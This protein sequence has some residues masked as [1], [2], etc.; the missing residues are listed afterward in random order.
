MKGLRSPFPDP[1]RVL[2]LCGLSDVHKG[3]VMC[4][5][6]VLDYFH[7]GS[8]VVKWSESSLDRFGP[9]KIV[10]SLRIQ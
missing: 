9:Q 10:F 7:G 4:F 6:G 2:G 1:F 5:L 8:D 3:R